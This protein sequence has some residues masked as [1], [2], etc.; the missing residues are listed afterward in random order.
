MADYRTL[1]L[2]FLVIGFELDL[3]GISASDS[4]FV[5]EGNT[6]EALMICGFLAY[7][8]AC[9]LLLFVKYGELGASRAAVVLSAVFALAAGKRKRNRKWT[10]L[11][12]VW[13]VSRCFNAK[14]DTHMI[15]GTCLF[16]ALRLPKWIYLFVS[17]LAPPRA[18]PP[19]AAN[20]W[21]RDNFRPNNF[22]ICFSFLSGLMA[23][24]Y[25]LPD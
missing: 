10:E 4:R 6:V 23:L 19:P 20:S 13:L 24:T 15:V 11:K 12:V 7:L 8:V 17:V 1:A 2:A 3:F 5:G 16:Q 22:S 9:M 21:W 18:S 25:R 14:H